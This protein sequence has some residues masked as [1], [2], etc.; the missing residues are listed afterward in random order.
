MRRRMLAILVAC[1]AIT[2][3]ETIDDQAYHLVPE[4]Y[5]SPVK[6]HLRVHGWGVERSS[7]SRHP[8]PV[9]FEKAYLEFNESGDMF[10][11]GQKQAILD[12]LDSYRDQKRPI[13]LVTYTHGWHHNASLPKPDEDEF[14]YNAT[15]FDYIMARYGEHV[16]RHF[17]LSDD[18][19]TP[20]VLG[21]Y[22][23]WRGERIKGGLSSVLTLDDRAQTADNIAANEG[24]G[25][26]KQ[27]LSEF[28]TK[29]TA[30][31]GGS[32]M[33]VTGH[34]L[35]GRMLSM[36]FIKD[37]AAGNNHP[38][39]PNTLIFALE[40]AIGA[41]CFD[42]VFKPDVKRLPGTRPGFIA[43][44]S[45]NDTAITK[46]YSL[47]TRIS[48][49][50]PPFCSHPPKRQAIGNY[51]DYIT[52]DLRFERVADKQSRSALVPAEGES[53]ST[54]FKPDGTTLL[55]PL[56]GSDNTTW[57]LGQG[58]TFWKYPYFDVDSQKYTLDDYILYR[59]TL[60]HGPAFRPDNAIWNIRVDER[61][62]DV[63]RSATHLS[64]GSIGAHHNGI[65]STGVA[66]ILGRIVFLQISDTVLAGN[67]TPR[68]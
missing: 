28:A 67:T 3:C 6:M 57:L 24:P 48:I 68:R 45:E 10:R 11:P 33:L 62:I 32:R 26:L 38:L 15:K 19:N 59:M 5:V 4:K 64:P 29:I 21:V 20:I 56:V 23:G 14:D 22:V 54:I 63:G 17:E 41:E 37:I 44:T 25:G 2:A 66:D 8:R 35:G 34:S 49:V 65:A 36:M 42:S 18:S 31:H 43:I 40:P 9:E 50:A 55:Y 13:F 47:S 53:V 1:A 27:A 60:T 51:S 39:G 12:R 46:F 16:R 52:H 58:K 61:L 7:S 30:I